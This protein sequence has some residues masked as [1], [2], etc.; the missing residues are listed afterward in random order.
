M[1]NIN[2]VQACCLLH[3]QPIN[4]NL[5]GQGIVTLFR[6]P[7]GQEDGIFMC[8]K[9][10]LPELEF[11]LLFCLLRAAPASYGGSQA[12]GLMGAVAAGLRHSHSQSGSGIQA[13]SATYT[14]ADSNARSLTH[15]ARWGR[16]HEHVTSWFLVGF[17]SAMP[18]WA[19]P[20]FFYT[21]RG[22]V[23]S[24][25]FL[26]WKPSGDVLISSYLQSLT[27]E[28]GQNVSHELN[29]GILA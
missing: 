26:V 28:P 15:W 11:R 17:V 20:S 3:S 8:Q 23:K 7:A 21:K 18:R 4:N 14:T 19:L 25:Y 13:A 1:L 6:K 5:L 2:G 29:K 22:G 9:T 27:S 12:R 16:E 24:N 10:I